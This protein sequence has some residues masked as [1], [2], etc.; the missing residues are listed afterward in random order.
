ML[1]T[2]RHIIFI[3]KILFCKH[4]FSLLNTFIRNGKDLESD[5]EADPEPD[6]YI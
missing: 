5:P 6:P 3:V 2:H 4:Y 1:L